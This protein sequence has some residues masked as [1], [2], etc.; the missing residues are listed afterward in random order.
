MLVLIGI[1]IV[2]LGFL[3]RLNPLL[4][5][6]VAAIVTG[7]CGGLDLVAVISAFGKAFTDSRYVSVWLLALPVIGLLERAGL[8]ER[9]RALIGGLRAATAGRL[10]LVYFLF[11]QA[12]A[13]LGL[14]AIA[15]QAQMVRP[16]IAPMAEAAAG[17]HAQDGRAASPATRQLVRAHAAAADNVAL[18]FGEDIFVAVASV[19]LIKGVLDQN[20]VQVQPMQISVWAIPTAVC[21]LATHGLRLLRLDRRL[22]R[23][24][25]SS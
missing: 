20:G 11:R 4:V 16:L 18:F 12:S 15:G 24:A 10:L 2:V 17:T 23:L 14:T 3:L 9:A 8:Q 13:A 5:V 19:L 21:A 25:Q 1:P 22:A 6:T 7:L